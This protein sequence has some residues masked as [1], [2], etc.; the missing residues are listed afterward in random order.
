[1]VMAM[2]VE[3]HLEERFVRNG[4]QAGSKDMNSGRRR[5]PSAVGRRETAVHD[6]NAICAETTVVAQEVFQRCRWPREQ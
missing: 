6:E 4:R 5:Q 1:M 3:C 2:S